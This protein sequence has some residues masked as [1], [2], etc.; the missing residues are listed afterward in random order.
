MIEYPSD[1]LSAFDG[2]R[3]VLPVVHVRDAEQTLRNVEMAYRNRCNGVFLIGHGLAADYVLDVAKQVKHVF[4]NFWLG[5]NF[6]DLS[7]EQSLERLE[8]AKNQDLYIEGLWCD[9]VGI[10]EDVE[11]GRLFANELQDIAQL[12]AELK[13]SGLLFGG[14][15]FKYQ[16]PIKNFKKAAELA[17]NYIDIVTTSGEATALPPDPEK[18]R[19]MASAANPKCLAIASGLSVE[20]VKLFPDCRIFLVSSSI[21]RSFYEFDEKELDE[22]VSAVVAMGQWRQPEYVW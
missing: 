21:S 3:V 15:A 5:V 17:R 13:W 10:D 19:I 6:L 16:R 7:P 4:P 20:N 22:F 12:R 8:W 1:M 14:V 18:I 11:T 2:R 9:S